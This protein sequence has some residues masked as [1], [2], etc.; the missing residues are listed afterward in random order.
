[1]W[2][3]VLTSKILFFH[4]AAEQRAWWAQNRPS[5]SIDDSALEA[6]VS[7]MWWQSFEVR[8]NCHHHFYLYSHNYLE[9]TFIS[10][11]RRHNTGCQA[12]QSLASPQLT[13][14]TRSTHRRRQGSTVLGWEVCGI[15]LFCVMFCSHIRKSVF[16]TATWQQPWWA[17]SLPP[18]AVDDSA[19][20][21][22]ELTRWWQSVEVR[23][24]CHPHCFSHSNFCTHLHLFWVYQQIK[25]TTQPT[26]DA[27]IKFKEM[28]S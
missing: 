7:M 9:L 20:E 16:H 13:P 24:H 22:I 14:R 11:R 26:N 23:K 3:F 2:C 19:L 21:E 25:S 12:S 10:C 5:S 1:M 17:Q 28:V 18:S 6:I 27:T 15:T 8:I 4:A